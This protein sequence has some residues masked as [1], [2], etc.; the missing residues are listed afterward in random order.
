MRNKSAPNKPK[1]S[2]KS[3]EEQ[4]IERTVTA[5]FNAEEQGRIR[6]KA[7]E[8]F[9]ASM[10]TAYDST[11][12]RAVD[13]QLKQAVYRHEGL[14]R[15]KVRDALSRHEIN[16]SSEIAR[17]IRD[18]FQKSFDFK[19]RGI[20]IDALS[21]ALRTAEISIGVTVP[22]SGVSIPGPLAVPK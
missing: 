6:E 20:L 12:A 1:K 9:L 16:V 18:E 7:E 19:V 14:I 13:D 3:L 11:I 2:S 15:D 8:V 4:A 21:K 10:Q 5:M 17:I 22:P